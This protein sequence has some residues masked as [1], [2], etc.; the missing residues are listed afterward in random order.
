MKIG[1]LGFGEVGRRFAA[2]LRATDARTELEVFDRLLHQTAAGEE[3]RRHA[4]AHRIVPASE[5]GALGAC[6]LVFSAVTADQT[7]AAAR[8]IAARPLN[9]CLFVDLNSAAPA[10][11]IECAAVIAAAGGRYVEAAVMTAVPPY[12]IRVPMLLG[13]AHAPLAEQVLAPMGFAARTVSTELGIASAIK[14]CRSVI[15]KGLESLVVESFTAARTL[16]VEAQELESLSATYPQFD[17]ERQGDYLRARGS[18]RGQRRA[19]EMRAC[20]A[21]LESAGAGGTMAAAAARRQQAMADRRA[22]GAFGDPLELKP[23]RERA[24]EWRRGR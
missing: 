23:W 13:G 1:L 9:N 15:I 18:L 6:D 3:M 5:A 12:G 20:A 17:G 8:S 21:M 10:T 11:K 22:A 4:T 16:G 14:L 19:E 7:L 24:D 2:D